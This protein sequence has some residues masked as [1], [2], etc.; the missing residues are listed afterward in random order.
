MKKLLLVAAMGLASVLSPTAQAATATS[1]FD[2]LINLTPSCSVS[3]AADITFA[4]TSF[5]VAAVT[6]STGF[7]VTCTNTLLYT[8]ALTTTSTAG[9]A[10]VTDAVVTLAYT[11]AL[12]APVGGGTGT[13]AAQAYTINGTMAGGQSGTCVG[14][15]VCSNAGSGNRNK[16]VT[17]TY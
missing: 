9:T 13:G 1:T 3:T 7:N 12:V 8:V 10:N 11:L 16:T 2:V 17:I 5:Q 6:P 4:Y 14:P 15:A